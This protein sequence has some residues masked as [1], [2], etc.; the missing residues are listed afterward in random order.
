MNRYL[1][2]FHC[3]RRRLDQSFARSTSQ[4]RQ[5]DSIPNQ[6][7]PEDLSDGRWRAAA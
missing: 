2:R 7:I 3:H 1:L 6:P 5:F 4:P